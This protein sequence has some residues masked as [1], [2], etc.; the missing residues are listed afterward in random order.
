MT[1]L[2]V[3]SMKL[4]DLFRHKPTLTANINSSALDM[5]RHNLERNLAERKALRI[6]Q[7]REAKQNYWK[8]Q[9]QQW[10]RDPLRQ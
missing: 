4:F 6:V 2:K 1:L 9:R 8:R 3:A 7:Q 10:K 5:F